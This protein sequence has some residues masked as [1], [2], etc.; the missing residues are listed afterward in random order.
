MEKL[1]KPTDAELEI[2]Q[3]L[4]VKGK[5]SVREVNEELC[6]T[7]NVGYTTTLKLLQIMYDKGTV[8]RT[9]EGRY[10][11]YF[12]TISEQQ[13]Q[14]EMLGSFINTAFKGSASQLVMRALGQQTVSHEELDEIKQLIKN[15]EES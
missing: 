6:K 8:F 2:L 9:E 1:F 14:N 15:I 7:R 12:P 3:I 10:H 5:A 13:T 4:W 11:I